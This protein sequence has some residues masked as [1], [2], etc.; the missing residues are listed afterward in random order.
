LQ[1]DVFRK[2]HLEV[3]WGLGGL[4]VLHVVMYPW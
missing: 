4:E 3:A 1:T 2:I